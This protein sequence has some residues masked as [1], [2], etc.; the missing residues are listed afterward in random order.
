VARVPLIYVVGMGRSGSTLLDILLGRLDGVVGVGEFIN[1]TDW[2]RADDKCACHE[3]LTLCPVWGEVIK[4]VPAVHEGSV[5][6]GKGRGPMVSSALRALFTRRPSAASTDIASLNHDV[7]AAACAKSGTTV[8]VD[9]SKDIARLCELEM[10]GLFDV[11]IIH[12]VRDARGVM[13]SKMKSLRRLAEDTPEM[14]A[15]IARHPN[16]ADSSSPAWIMRR[17]VVRNLLIMALGVTRWRKRYRV[18][19]YEDLAAAPD[20]AIRG[21]AEWVEGVA[22]TDGETPPSAPHNIG[23]NRMRLRPVK[24]IRVDDEWR[25]KL[26]LRARLAFF[27]NGGPLIASLASTLAAR[28]PSRP[29]RTEP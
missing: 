12:L 21:I 7:L 23:G 9:S 17:W 2:V 3:P 26:G 27:V 22:V 8:V 18:L 14:L 24:S 13:W 15:A 11:Y 4:D 25:T 1:F 16:R 28:A 10:S 5:S 29:D 20:E 6:F 19:L